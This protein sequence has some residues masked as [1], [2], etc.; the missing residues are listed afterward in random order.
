[1]KDPVRRDSLLTVVG[2]ALLVAVFMFVVY[3]P[4]RNAADRLEREIAAAEQSIHDVPARIAEL[5][6]LGAA[7]GLRNDFLKETEQL[8]PG[9]SD[10]HT[11]ICQVADLAENCGLAVTRLEPLPKT[12]HQ[13]YQTLPFRVSF[14]GGFR[15]IVTFLRGLEE[16]AR[17]FTIEEFSI[18]GENEQIGDNVDADI[19]FSVYVR[20]AESSESA[21]NNASSHRLRA[22]T[23]IR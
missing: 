16:R 18:T 23:E 19:H 3:L 9:D 5:E 10:L 22:D 1:M 15:G 4:G 12:V 7:L 17:L 8:I 14:R 6:S 20:R 2:L 21:D 13:S 11:V